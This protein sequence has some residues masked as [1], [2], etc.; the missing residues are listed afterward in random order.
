MSKMKKIRGTK[1]ETSTLERAEFHEEYRGV[2]I[3]AIHWAIF[4]EH[5]TC[6]ASALDGTRDDEILELREHID[7][8]LDGLR[9]IV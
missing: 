7:A 6:Y 2:K 3:Y 1:I 5:G 9:E 4:D 8:Q